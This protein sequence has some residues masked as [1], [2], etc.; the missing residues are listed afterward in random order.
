MVTF[1]LNRTGNAK[2]NQGSAKLECED[3]IKEPG[4]IREKVSNLKIVELESESRL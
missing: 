1:A 2:L 4:K 3:R